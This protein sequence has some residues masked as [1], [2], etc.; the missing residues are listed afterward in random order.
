MLEMVDDT[1]DPRD[2]CIGVFDGYD[3]KVYDTRRLARIAYGEKP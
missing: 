3:N 1:T 2:D